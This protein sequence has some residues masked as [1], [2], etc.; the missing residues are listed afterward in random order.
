[1]RSLNI[2]ALSWDLL[3]I[4]VAIN[5]PKRGLCIFWTRHQ[6]R[7]RIVRVDHRKHLWIHFFDL[8]GSL[9]GHV[10][11]IPKASA[12]LV[13]NTLE[14]A[15]WLH[16][17]AP[18][19]TWT[20]LHV[21]SVGRTSGPGRIPLGWPWSLRTGGQYPNH[22]QLAINFLWAKGPPS[23]PMHRQPGSPI[24]LAHKHVH[25]QKVEALVDQQPTSVSNM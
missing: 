10:R 6:K 4:E 8:L 14:H 11:Q 5:P 2:I 19:C 17:A 22:P 21:D 23:I 7:P 16:L 3:S 24:F 20:R 25:T 1:M 12:L 18:G 13:A 9:G 15:T